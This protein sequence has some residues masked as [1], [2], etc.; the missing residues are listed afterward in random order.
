MFDYEPT[1]IEEPFEAWRCV[2][3]DGRTAR[4]MVVP[5]GNVVMVI[6]FVNERVEGGR[7]SST[8]RPP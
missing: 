5:Q 6:W 8:G 7:R 4:A 1:R 3:P 2:L